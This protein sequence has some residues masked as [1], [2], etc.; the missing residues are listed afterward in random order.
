[1][2]GPQ[3]WA[4]RAAIR[5]LIIESSVYLR[6]NYLNTPC[7]RCWPLSSPKC[8]TSMSSLLPVASKVEQPKVIPHTTHHTIQLV[9]RDAV[10]LNHKS[11]KD[12][13]S[14]QGGGPCCRVI[15]PFVSGTLFFTAARR[16]RARARVKVVV[17]VHRV[18][19]DCTSSPCWRG[20]GIGEPYSS[21]EGRVSVLE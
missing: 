11:E 3:A 9:P 16:A 19:W 17:N 21:P 6:Y 4:H 20:D 5:R 7:F 12:T 15:H 13:N 18:S 8:F 10:N 2:N 1:M 14:T